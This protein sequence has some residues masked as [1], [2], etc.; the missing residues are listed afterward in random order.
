MTASHCVSDPFARRYICLCVRVG[1]VGALGD[2]WGKYCRV[3]E[4]YKCDSRSCEIGAIA[5]DANNDGDGV[6]DDNAD[7]GDYNNNNNNDNGMK[8]D[9]IIVMFIHPNTPTLDMNFSM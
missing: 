4:R 5:C 3:G 8:I 7:A 6:D 1:F 2:L 9:I